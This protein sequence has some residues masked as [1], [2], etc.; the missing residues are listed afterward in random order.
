MRKSALRYKTKQGADR[1]K[2]KFRL[3]AFT[4][5]VRLSVLPASIKAA[6]ATATTTCRTYSVDGSQVACISMQKVKSLYLRASQTMI[7]QHMNKT[8]S[9]SATW[10]RL[11]NLALQRPSW[12]VAQVRPVSCSNLPDSLAY[13]TLYACQDWALALSFHSCLRLLRTKIQYCG[14]KLKQ[15]TRYKE[16]A[17]SSK[18]WDE[19]CGRREKVLEKLARCLR[20]SSA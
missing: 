17:T 16:H 12:L 2:L 15:S 9:G 5:F 4:F 7:D 1:P 20:V 13:S 19:E 14:S 10:S 6:V 8:R 3:E 11:W 18:R